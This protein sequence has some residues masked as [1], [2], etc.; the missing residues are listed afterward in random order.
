MLNRL[1]Q[2]GRKIEA[3]EGVEEVLVAADFAGNFK[4]EGVFAEDINEYE[5]A[6]QR[7]TLAEKPTLKGHRM[8]T[9]PFVQE[10]V[11]GASGTAA[12]WHTDLRGMGFSSTGLKVIELGTVTNGPFRAGQT[13]GNNATQGSATVTGIAVKQLATPTRLVYMPLTGAFN[14]TMSVFNYETP[15]TS[16]PIT[17]NPANAG[18]G[19]RPLSETDAALPPSVTF[20]ERVG[21]YRHTVIGSRARGG[22]SMR[23]N[24]PLLLRGEYMGA[25]VLDTGNPGRFRT[26]SPLT[27]VPN[28]AAAPKVTKGIP[29]EFRDGATVYTPILTEL[30]IEIDNTLAPRPTIANNDLADSGYLATRISGRV[31]SANLDPEKVLGG[32]FDYDAL[33]H[34]GRTFKITAEIGGI[35]E[36]NGLVVIHAPAVEAVGQLTFGDRDGIRTQPHAGKFTGDDEDEV[37]VFHVF[38]P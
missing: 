1:T 30:P 36:A 22:L 9:V 16:A 3:V 8:A 19:F 2:R 33:M 10:L 26:G 31:F 20:E 23:M 7:A 11:G 32:T 35:A 15:Q 21:G 38:V 12:P 4:G 13:I 24:E 17:V 28:F 25:A 34:L 37:F 6:L 14:N 18:F 5:R 27:G 29:L